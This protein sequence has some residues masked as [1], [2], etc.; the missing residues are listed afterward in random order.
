MDSMQRVQN[1]KANIACFN[2]TRLKQ[3]M[4]TGLI[5]INYMSSINENSLLTIP[6]RLDS[7]TKFSLKTYFKP[8]KFLRT[9]FYFPNFQ[10][11]YLRLLLSRCHYSGNIF[12]IQ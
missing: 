10:E 3:L 5:K 9:K 2:S 7:N 8:S 12:T 6:V 11:K 1:L 4:I